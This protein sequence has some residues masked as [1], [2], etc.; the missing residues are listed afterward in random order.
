MWSDFFNTPTAAT[1]ATTLASRQLLVQA[2]V[3]AQCPSVLQLAVLLSH[4]HY[5][6]NRLADGERWSS[7]TDAAILSEPGA[8]PGSQPEAA[9]KPRRKQKTTQ[10]SGRR[11]KWPRPTTRSSPRTSSGP[12]KDPG[13]DGP[14]APESGQRPT[15]AA[16]G[17]HLHLLFQ[18]QRR[19]G[20][21]PSAAAGGGQVAQGHAGG[22]IVIED[23]I[24]ASPV[25]NS[26]PNAGDTGHQTAGSSGRLPTDA[27]GPKVSNSVGEQ[28]GA[29][30]GMEWTREAP[31][32]LQQDSS[33]LDQDESALHR[34]DGQLQQCQPHHEISFAAHQA[35]QPGDS[36]APSDV[37]PRGQDVRAAGTPSSVPNLD[38]PGSK[39]QAAQS[40]PK[41]PGDQHRDQLGTETEQGSGKGQITPQRQSHEGAQNRG[42]MIDQSQMIEIVS[43]MELANPNNWCFCNVAVY[44]ML[45]TMLNLRTYEPAHWGTQC[46]ELMNFLLTARNGLCSLATQPFFREILQCWGRDDLGHLESTISQQDSSEFI[47]VW[48]QQMQTPAFW[49]QWEKRVI[50]SDAPHAMDAS[51]ERYMPICLKFD[52]LSVR[53]EFCTL[54]SLIS[55]WQQVDGM[56]TA[57]LHAPDCLCVHIDRCV[58]NPDMSISKCR[59]KLQTDEECFFP[60]FSGD[61]I[62]HVFHGYTVVAVMSHLGSDAAGH[63]RAAMKIRSMIGQC[64]NPIQWLITDDWRKPEAVWTQPIWIQENTTMAWLVKTERL[65]QPFYTFSHDPCRSST[66]ELLRMLADPM[67]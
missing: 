59:S 30:H 44:S 64:N 24:E 45:W 2:H 5:G 53:S 35:G 27:G 39:P 43:K 60:V 10:T 51:R 9:A 13:N 34:T 18:L 32:G 21:A 42:M 14:S 11:S 63:Y 52:E 12:T 7:S 55:S 22:C 49:M 28:D 41:L 38:T 50:I 33:E 65:Q 47:H 56:T 8:T 4:I 1:D 40:T 54:N 23:A 3:R 6:A 36:L 48:L 61:G 16:E 29:V 26:D 58:L 66:A 19:N 57:L 67:S 17:N 15:G 20:G 37:L 25:A 62:A 46:Q 31:A